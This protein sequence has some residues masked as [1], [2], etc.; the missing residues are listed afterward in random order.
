MRRSRDRWAATAAVTAILA[1]GFAA[2]QAL[3]ADSGKPIVDHVVAPVTATYS[4]DHTEGGKLCGEEIVKYLTAKY[5]TPKGN[6]VDLEGI[7]GIVAA[8]RREKALPTS[9]P[10]IPTSK[11]WLAPM[12][13]SIPTRPTR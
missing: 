4:M 13:A 6:I 11:S 10:N 3:A 7:A 9:S 5:G 2:T 12:A 8:A 1:V